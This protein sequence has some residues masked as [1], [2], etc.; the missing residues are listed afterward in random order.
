MKKLLII[1][2]LLLATLSYA[3]GTPV[4]MDEDGDPSCKDVTNIKFSNDSVT[5]NRDGSASVSVSTAPH[6]QAQHTEADTVD[7]GAA[8]AGSW[9]VLKYNTEKF[10]D[11]TWSFNTGTYRLTLPAG[12]YWFDVEHVFFKVDNAQIAIYNVTDA[13]YEEYGITERFNAGTSSS[14]R[15]KVQAKVVIAGTKVFE[16]RYQVNATNAGNG[17]G[18]AASFGGGEV[19]G[20]WNV[21][22]LSVN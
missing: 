15:A 9:K 11:K 8:T 5:C 1:L 12:T 18:N 16:I 10:D 17:I 6:W 3:G 20:Y 22:K 14:G 13:G 2:M 21:T 19:Y 7:G 4:I